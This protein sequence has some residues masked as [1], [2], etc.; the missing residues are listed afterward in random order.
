MS[1]L[2]I[3]CPTCGRNLSPRKWEELQGTRPDGLGLIWESYGRGGLKLLERIYDSDNIEDIDLVKNKLLEA[4]QE[5][6]RS[7]I[8][9]R[10]DLS[11]L[12]NDLLEDDD[13]QAHT[14]KKSPFTARKTKFY[15]ATEYKL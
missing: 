9:T 3:I 10:S 2:S 13:I 7:G 6:Y 14:E 8:I 4:V 12:L 15:S 5:Y 1:W 11:D